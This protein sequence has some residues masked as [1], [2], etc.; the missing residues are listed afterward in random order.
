M[1]R[2]IYSPVRER[3]AVSDQ[4]SSVRDATAA[5]RAAWSRMWAGFCAHYDTTLP[6]A[7]VHELWRR[8]LDPQHPVSA[9]VATTRDGRGVLGFAHYVLRP[10]TFSSRMVCYLEDLWVD[11]AGRGAGIGRQLVDSLI[12]RGRERGWRRVYW[13]TETDNEARRLYDRV[14]TLTEYVRYDVTLP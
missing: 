3:G 10:H 14:A 5:D 8:I 2:S 6:E 13:H 1:R 4:S 12:Q 7:D 11:P 9:L